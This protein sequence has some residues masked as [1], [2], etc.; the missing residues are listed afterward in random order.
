MNE[1]YETWPKQEKRCEVC[2]GELRPVIEFLKR[3]GEEAYQKWKDFVKE[4]EGEEVEDST[5]WNC[6][7]CGK[8]YDKDF[9]LT[10]GNVPWLK[11]IKEYYE[12]E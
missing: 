9:K 11:D 12:V 10:G 2:F 7:K 6:L 3:N 4:T 8:V 1:D 5:N